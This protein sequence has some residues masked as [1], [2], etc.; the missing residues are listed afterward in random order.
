MTFL[1]DTHTF[2]WLLREPEKLPSSVR[3]IAEEPS[4]ALALSVVTPWEMAIK[5]NL[6]KLDACEILD[7]FERLVALAGYSILETTIDH[8]IRGGRLPLHHR[9]LFDRLLAAQ[10]LELRLPLVSG[11]E[12]FD[13]YGVH[14]IWD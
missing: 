6:G 10:A 8:V 7:N 9:D 12:A 3:A 13:W 5:A 1:L 14:R 2:L 4:N 11:N